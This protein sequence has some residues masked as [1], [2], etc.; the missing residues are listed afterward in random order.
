MICPKCEKSVFGVVKA[1]GLC[2]Q[3]DIVHTAELKSSV[4]IPKAENRKLSTKKPY[5]KYQKEL[6]VVSDG[7]GLFK[8]RRN[9]KPEWG[10]FS[11]AQVYQTQYWAEQ[12]AK[13]IGKG[14]PVKLSS[15]VPASGMMA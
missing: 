11:S 4:V 15:M 6:H 12:A 3:C 7:N 1:S 14:T 13:I 8:Q 5:P 9:T 10:K 2:V